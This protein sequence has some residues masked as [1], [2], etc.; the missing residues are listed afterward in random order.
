[1]CVNDNSEYI[2]VIEP[3]KYFLSKTVS[4]DAPIMSYSVQQ[5]QAFFFPSVHNEKTVT[6]DGTTRETVQ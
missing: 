4:T 3:I 5:I 2:I 1:M 6:P